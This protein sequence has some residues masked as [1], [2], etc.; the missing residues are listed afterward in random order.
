MTHVCTT[1]DIMRHDDVMMEARYRLMCFTWLDHLARLVSCSRVRGHA[2]PRAYVI[3]AFAFSRI[4]GNIP[5]EANGEVRFACRALRRGG[6]VGATGV[7]LG[8]QLARLH[9]ILPRVCSKSNSKSVFSTKISTT[10]THDT[11][12]VEAYERLS[13]VSFR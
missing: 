7:G 1:E 5:A 10:M 4:I 9:L 13:S 12:V 11:L 8:R 6:A 2:P 3:A